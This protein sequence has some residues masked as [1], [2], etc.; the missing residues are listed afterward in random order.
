MS[1]STAGASATAQAK[2]QALQ[3]H[4]L[5]VVTGH[6]LAGVAVA[7][8]V[9]KTLIGLRDMARVLA[10]SQPL[11]ATAK[12]FLVAA[13]TQAILDSWPLEARKFGLAHLLDRMEFT[14]YRSLSKTLDRGRYHKLYLDELP[15]RTPMSRA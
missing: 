10:E 12:L 3:D 8:G 1:A 11:E 15:L 7:M 6:R 5:A 14:T 2:K 13:P 9:G 4:I